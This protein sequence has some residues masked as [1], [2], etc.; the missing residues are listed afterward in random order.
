MESI[1]A[2]VTEHG[3]AW[4]ARTPRG[5]LSWY[6]ARL[7][8]S[9]TDADLAADIRKR[10]NAPGFTAELVAESVDYALL[11]HARNRDLCARVCSGRI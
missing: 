4:D 11:C 3:R 5:D 2:T 8:V 10:C 6:V 9:V 7:H 1:M